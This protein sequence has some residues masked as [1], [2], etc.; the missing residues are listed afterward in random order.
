MI[1]PASRSQITAALAALA[2]LDVKISEILYFLLSSSPQHIDSVSKPALDD[3]SDQGN[4]LILLDLFKSNSAFANGTNAW[5]QYCTTGHLIDEVNKLT[6][7]SSGWHG[8]ARSST[9]EQFEAIDFS[10]LA[11]TGKSIAPILWGMF[12]QLFSIPSNS[13]HGDDS[14]IHVDNDIDA[15]DTSEDHSPSSMSQDPASKLRELVC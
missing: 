10:S 3:L 5:I 11:V 2:S 8:Y 1:R 15:M 9:V 6:K 13:D 4:Y 12:E 7:K 14:I